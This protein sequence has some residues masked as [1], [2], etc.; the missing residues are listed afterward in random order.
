MVCNSFQINKIFFESRKFVVGSLRPIQLDVCKN[1][2]LTNEKS[3][4]LWAM[5]SR[6]PKVLP[7]CTFKF[8]ARVSAPYIDEGCQTGLETK[9]I[10][11]LRERLE[12]KVNLIKTFKS[13]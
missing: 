4:K 10:S 1:G 6:I 2:T 8:C 11:V 7:N 3:T 5:Q 9:I 13:F 12:F